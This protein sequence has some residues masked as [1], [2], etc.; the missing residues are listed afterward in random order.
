MYPYLLISKGLNP[1]LGRRA[2]ADPEE[3]HREYY[4]EGLPRADIRST[5]S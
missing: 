1:G 4:I 5:L 3:L 2:H